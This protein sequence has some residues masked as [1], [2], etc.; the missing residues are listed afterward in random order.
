MDVGT[1][2]TSQEIKKLLACGFTL[3]VK[4]NEGARESSTQT[5]KR[6]MNIG[7]A[8]KHPTKNSKRSTKWRHSIFKEAKKR[9]S[10]AESM[11]AIV[12]NESAMDP[13]PHSIFHLACECG[14]EYFVHVVENPWCTCPNLMDRV[15][16]GMSYLACKHIYFVYLH[17]LGLDKL[18]DMGIH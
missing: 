10:K 17:V 1:N 5:I 11:Q 14:Q 12:I 16:K 7:K 18:K 13:A 8:P 9:I 4:V 6:K 15:T 2:I 3:D